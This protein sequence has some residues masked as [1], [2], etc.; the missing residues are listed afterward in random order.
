[1]TQRVHAF[2]DDAMGNDDAVAIAARIAGGEITARE[3]AHAA[4]ARVRKVNGE[5]NAVAHEG[6]DEAVAA[7]TT[8]GAFAGVPTFVKDN[9]DVRG[10]PTGN[11]TA[12]VA[13]KPHAE[14]S[15]VV[16]HLR[17]LGFAF[18]GKSTLP[19]FGFNASTEW[20]GGRSTK[21]PWD[22]R[23]SA[24]ASS[25]GSAAL[26]A[27]GAV[28]LA[29]AN[30]GGGSI[31]IPAAACGL[32]GLKPTRGRVPAD[33][34][35]DVLPVKIISDGIVSRSVRDTAAYFAAMERIAPAKGLPVIGDVTAPG[36]RRLRVGVFTDNV[37]T[38][39]RA[40]PETRVAVHATADLMAELGHDVTD[41]GAPVDSRFVDDFTLYWGFLAFSMATA[42]KKLLGPDF[43]PS[44][45]DPLTVGLKRHFQKKMVG[46]PAALI[47]LRR[48]AEA[49]AKVF[50]SVDVI[51]SPVVAR[52]TPELGYLSPDQP[53]EQLFGRLVGYAAYT[54]LNNAAG[55][56]GM[57]LP[58]GRTENGMPI[59]VHF[60]ANHGAERT[61]L[62]LAF[63][64]E[65]ARP[66]PT[67]VP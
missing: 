4:V 32:V 29:H 17:S 3:A 5:L 30:D 20:R 48:T 43:D 57:S 41:F 46:F 47:R 53:F 44:K 36:K 54:P 7:P 16:A 6:F 65:Q 58:L 11:G 18:L 2:A 62:E 39:G 34:T 15:N 40:D 49:Y 13:A 55:G 10:W 23:F 67:L 25:G 31:R 8:S 66:F 38:G 33:K 63:E 24:G 56:P 60:A 59:G 28:P 21:N 19:E 50:E 12:A 22:T 45:L 42:G 61:L 1:M 37:V 27:S 14:D 51:L 9:T 64:L 26:V 52:T 35:N